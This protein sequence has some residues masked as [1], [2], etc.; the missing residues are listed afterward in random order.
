MILKLRNSRRLNKTDKMKD[1]KEETN[2]EIVET[3]MVSIENQQMSRTLEVRDKVVTTATKMTVQAEAVEA[4]E[5][6]AEAVEADQ[7]VAITEV[8]TTED[9]TNIN[10]STSNR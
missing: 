5:V 1:N 8:V 10:N 6:V 4:A 9:T 3:P 7:K 2:K